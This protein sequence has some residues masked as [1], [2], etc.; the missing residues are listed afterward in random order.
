MIHKYAH[1]SK[2]KVT[3][4]RLELEKLEIKINQRFKEFFKSFL[5]FT[6]RKTVEKI[7]F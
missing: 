5:D 3:H 6:L 4:N 2:W 7:D 1:T